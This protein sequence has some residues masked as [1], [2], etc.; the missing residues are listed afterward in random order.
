MHS[1]HLDETQVQGLLHGELAP[2][3][4]MAA[5]EHLERCDACRERVSAAAREEAEVFALL[6]A[7]DHPVPEIGAQAIARRAGAPSAVRLPWAAGIVVALG[8]AGVA[9]AAPGSPLPRFVRALTG[10]VRPK[11]EPATRPVTPASA[12]PAAVAGVA[13]VPG[14]RLLIVFTSSQSEGAA[15][16]RL[17]DS[18]VVVVRAPS[19]AATFSSDA[20]R[21]VIDNRGG[22]GTFDIRIPR[23]APRVEILVD[24]TRR[25]L[26]ERGVVASSP[27]VAVDAAYTIP[28][29]DQQR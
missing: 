1:M 14:E 24:G 5:R 23:A 11:A 3:G 18:A 17:T 6:G 27:A 26:V 10:W 21:L 22:A 2:A 19:A 20:D 25:F 9:Y 7:V 16:V 15:H 12:A 8:I 28:L 13:F 29:V 4:E